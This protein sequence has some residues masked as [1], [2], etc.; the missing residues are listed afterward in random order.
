MC[1]YIPGRIFPLAPHGVIRKSHNT[2]VI[3]TVI[4]LV[5]SPVDKSLIIFMCHVPTQFVFT[6][7][8][9]IFRITFCFLKQNFSSPN[10]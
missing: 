9:K 7:R 8:L 2:K 4:L 10:S 6:I 3:C 5:V 1:M